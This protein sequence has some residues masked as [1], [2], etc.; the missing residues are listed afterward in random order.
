MPSP[1]RIALPILCLAALSWAQPV[2]DLP[3]QSPEA[4]VTQTFGYTTA[5]VKYSRP[6]VNGRVIWGGQEPYDRVWRAGANE[7]TNVEI[8][9]DVANN[10]S[11]LTAGPFSIFILPEKKGGKDSWTVILSRNTKGWG[12][13]GYNDKDDAL[14]VTVAPEKAPH[15]ERMEFEFE[16]ITDGGATLVL[17]WEKLRGSLAVTAEFLETGKAN[18]AK[19]IPNIKPDDPYGWLGAARFYWTHNID[20]KQA[21]EWADKSI[22]VKPLFGNLWVK[23]GWLA[24]EKRFAEALETGRLARA[25]A[26]KDPGVASQLP[27][28]DKTMKGWGKK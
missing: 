25:E 5:T 1:L 8:S 16:N 7:P 3:R 13:F 10:T 28:I 22:A 4:S 20:R 17:H 12:A 21:M 27:E 19:G 14:R 9:R 23:A 6:A 26:A 15:K 11:P 24:E 2:V 18:I